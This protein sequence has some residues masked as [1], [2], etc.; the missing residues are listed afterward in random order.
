MS[1]RLIAAIEALTAAVKQLAI[2]E[3]MTYNETLASPDNFIPIIW[4]YD[5]ASGKWEE[6]KE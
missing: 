4:H 5:A 3:T 2:V 6:I 1:D